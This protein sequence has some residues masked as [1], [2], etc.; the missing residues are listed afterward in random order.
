MTPQSSSR[1][2]QITNPPS[3]SADLIA[4]GRAAYFPVYS[5]RDMIV[6]HGKGARLW[7][8]EG[9]EYI[10]LGTGIGVNILGHQEAD[11]VTAAHEQLQ[12]LWHTSNIYFTEPVVQLAAELI[13]ATFAD[14]GF[15]ANSGAEA[16]E[17]AIKVA[18]KFSSFHHASTKREIITFSGSFH[19]RTLTTVT[20]TAQPKHQ[21]GFEPLPGGFTYCPF[22]DFEAFEKLISDQT[23][24]VLIEPVQ[25]EGGLISTQPGF[26]KHLQ[27]LCHQHKALLIFDE[28][29]SGMGRT[30]RFFAHQWEAGIQ[31]DIV[32]VAKALGGGLPIG[33]MLTTETVAQMFKLGD[34][35]STFGGNPVV[36]A[37]ARV[38]LR[39]IGSPPLMANVKKQGGH[40]RKR[41]EALNQSLDMFKE[42][43]GKGLMIGAALNDQWQGQAR[44][45]MEACRQQGVLI[46]QAGPHI[47]RFLPPLNITDEEL[48]TGMDRV[49][50]AITHYIADKKP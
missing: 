17:A 30:G 2:G 12:K 42:I 43:R 25:G 13:E 26:L 39:K 34:H 24:A 32:T 47:L 15:F 44:H 4:K 41:L 37:V 22:N 38:V 23:C 3:A 1:R 36:A 48:Q 27:T 31:P 16:N 45:L 11:L 8:L 10:D 35:G 20:A 7:D 29:Q 46:L 33:A 50:E 18:R 5:P 19:G 21:V 14:R 6:D 9:H 28:I 49:G 40:L